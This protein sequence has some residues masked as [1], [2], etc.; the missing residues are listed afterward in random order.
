MLHPELANHV[1]TEKDKTSKTK[2][3]N[4]RWSLSKTGDLPQG[5]LRDYL[6]IFQMQLP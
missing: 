2:I 4:K 6:I 1:A 3:N 5:Y